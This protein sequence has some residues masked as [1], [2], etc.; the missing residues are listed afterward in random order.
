M[1]MKMVQ[2]LRIV[3][4]NANLYF[5]NDKGETFHS[6]RFSDFQRLDFVSL[7]GNGNNFLS[8]MIGILTLI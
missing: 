2:F 5:S 3:G 7:N 6:I 4:G 1:Q 8:R